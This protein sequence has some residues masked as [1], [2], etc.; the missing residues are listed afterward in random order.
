MLGALGRILVKRR[1]AT[2]CC[3]V[4]QLRRY[5]LLARVSRRHACQA[6]ATALCKFVSLGSV[7]TPDAV[8]SKP[9]LLAE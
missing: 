2:C 4:G 6:A 8:G 3:V 7:E 5:W 9:G 1:L